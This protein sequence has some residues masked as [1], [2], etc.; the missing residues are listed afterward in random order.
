MSYP[1]Y[2]NLSSELERVRTDICIR[3]KEALYQLSY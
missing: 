2:G 1:T 3:D